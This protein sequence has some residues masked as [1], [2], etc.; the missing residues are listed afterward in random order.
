M[1]LI[2]RIRAF[3]RLWTLRLGLLGRNYLDSALSV[4]EARVLYDLAEPG[5]HTARGLAQALVLDEAQLSRH[6]ARFRQLG[7]IETRAD[8]GD[9]RQK[10][11]SL[12]APGR[13]LAMDLRARSRRDL[14][15]RIAALGPDAATLL[16]QGIAALNAALEPPSAGD[17]RLRGLEPGDLGWVTM[18]H[19][20]LYAL[21]EGYD[22]SFE[23]LVARILADFIETR[24]PA[25]DGAWIAEADGRRLGCVFLRR[26][27]A[28]TA[29]LRLFL[30]LPEARGLGL[31]RRM[32]A[33]ATEFAR[34]AG[35]RRMV[36]WTHES[37]EAACALY[38]KT[39]WRMVARA[40]AQAFGQ[41]VI[42][43]HWEIGL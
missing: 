12:T 40:P 27:D 37:H 5:T 25:A 24:D 3:N 20:R 7:L 16:D 15:A 18:E 38:R 23:A 34:A 10:L 22:Q 13:D 28:A 39:G 1:D 9:R 6:L 17:V 33:T 35:Y 26:E 43:Q 21:D 14:A 36:L 31:G 8:P 42:D 4:T 11:L 41:A 2:D 29:R 30:L 19:G 32:L